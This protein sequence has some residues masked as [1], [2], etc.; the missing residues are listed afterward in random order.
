MTIKPLSHQWKLTNKPMNKDK[1]LN[2]TL[3]SNDKTSTVES[4]LNMWALTKKSHQNVQIRHQI[5]I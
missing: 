1:P 4:K 3:S 2:K 5:L